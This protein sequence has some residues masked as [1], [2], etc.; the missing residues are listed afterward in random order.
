[1]SIGKLLKTV[2]KSLLYIPV[3]LF[4]LL[5]GASLLFTSKFQSLTGLGN[6]GP[7]QKAGNKQVKR[8]KQWKRD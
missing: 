8:G 5:N 1:M 6:P 7:T 3:N 2:A 4:W